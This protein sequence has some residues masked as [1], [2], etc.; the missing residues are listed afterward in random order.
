MAETG[1]GEVRFGDFD[2]DKVPQPCR[3]IPDLGR[4]AIAVPI[5]VG[6]CRL[7]RDVVAGQGVGIR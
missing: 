6:P 4:V 5:F 1:R 2:I 7:A 3:F